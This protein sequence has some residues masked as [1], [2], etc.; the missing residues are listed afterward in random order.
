MISPQLTEQYGQV[1][2]V[3]VL[4]VSL[5]SRTSASASFGEKPR[6]ATLEVPNPAAVTLKNCLRVTYIISPPWWFTPDGN[7]VQMF[8]QIPGLISTL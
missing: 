2:R 1:L 4:P 8:D 7:V 6:A 5:N 3:S